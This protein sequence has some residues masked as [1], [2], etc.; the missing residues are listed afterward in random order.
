MLILLAIS[1]N[2]RQQNLDLT[3]SQ[4]R[5]NSTGASIPS[6]DYRDGV[7][8]Y[9]NFTLNTP[10]PKQTCRLFQNPCVC[11]CVSLCIQVRESYANGLHVSCWQ[12][13]AHQGHL[14]GD[15]YLW[16]L[17][18][19]DSRPHSVCTVRVQAREGKCFYF[20]IPQYL[21]TFI[22]FMGEE[23]EGENTWLPSLSLVFT[24][25]CALLFFRLCSV[26]NIAQ[27]SCPLLWALGITV[28]LLQHLQLPLFV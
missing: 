4:H 28:Y 10:L 12:C 16:K 3:S 21:P 22:F 25:A 8:A 19:T 5:C 20:K 1:C 2:T 15:F 18:Q 23:A 17:W 7:T 11:E 13:K 14:P 27:T 9:A 24:E 26:C 6:S